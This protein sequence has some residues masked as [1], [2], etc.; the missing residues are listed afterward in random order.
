M[1]KRE[2]A[3]LALRAT[4]TLLNNIKDWAHFQA[5]KR[6]SDIKPSIHSLTRYYH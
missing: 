3:L 1:Q 2:T 6:A 4:K 5:K